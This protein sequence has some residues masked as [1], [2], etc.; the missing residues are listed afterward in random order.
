MSVTYVG[1]LDGASVGY[2]DPQGLDQG[3][4]PQ[5][6]GQVWD[7]NGFLPVSQRPAVECESQRNVSPRI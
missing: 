3:L 4:E 2:L 7:C 5:W 6:I 1:A